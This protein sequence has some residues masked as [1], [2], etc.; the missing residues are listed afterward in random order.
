MTVVGF[1]TAHETVEGSQVDSV[2]SS[3]ISLRS[4]G[5]CMAPTKIALMTMCGFVVVLPVTGI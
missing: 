3:L 1:T 2:F 5:S 4:G